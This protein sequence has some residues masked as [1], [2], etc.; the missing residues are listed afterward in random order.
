[1]K[2]A[3]YAVLLGV[4]ATIVLAV[5]SYSKNPKP[6]PVAE[7]IAIAPAPKAKLHGHQAFLDFAKGKLTKE[8]KFKAAMDGVQAGPAPGPGDKVVAPINPNNEVCLQG[9]STDP[10]PNTEPV[11]T[12]PA[13]FT[14]PYD[15][16]ARTQAGVA[17]ADLAKAGAQVLSNT[18]NPSADLVP[19]HY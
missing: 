18:A 13:K 9:Q 12:V 4:A 16:D 7:T 17:E 11:V 1:M 19:F 10:E 8:A 5:P 15:L 6:T 2:K 14:S 3:T